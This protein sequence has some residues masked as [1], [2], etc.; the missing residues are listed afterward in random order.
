MPK[1]YLLFDA[2]GVLV[3]PDFDF[4]A[5]VARQNGLEMDAAEVAQTHWE[6]I[7]AIDLE[8][9]QNGVLKD[10][11]PNGYAQALFKNHC[12][13]PAQLEA[14]AARVQARHHER[15]IWAN[16]QSWVA[17]TL[18]SLQAAGYRMAVISNSDGSVEQI[19]IDLD[20]RGYFEAVF[21]SEI[22]GYS[23]P[24]VRFFQHALQTL[25]LDPQDAVYIGDVVTIDM[26]GAQRAG[27][28]G[29]HV[30][31]LNLYAAWPGTHIPDITH[32]KDWLAENFP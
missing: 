3:F 29:I 21:D 26:D 31:P 17:P 24:D 25:K 22:I 13:S 18:Q 9:R 8:T 12:P 16:T 7:Y 23:K 20:L 15:H 28:P 1:P 5:N 10:P 2:G 30:D 32:L 27:L 14:V 6:L 11:F 4:L 19:L